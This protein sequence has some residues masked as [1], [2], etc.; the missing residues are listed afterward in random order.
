MA[1][2]A[3]GEGDTFGKAET[4]R[5][6]P[7]VAIGLTGDAARLMADFAQ[8]FPSSPATADGGIVLPPLTVELKATPRGLAAQIDPGCFAADLY[9]R[10]CAAHLCDG[11]PVIPPTAERVSAMLA[12]TDFEP[13]HALVS[14]LPPSGASITVRSLAVNA[15]MAGCRSE[16]F[17]ILITAFQAIAD[18]AYRAYQ[19]AITTLKDRQP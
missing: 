8:R 7:D 2:P 5:I 3:S 12:F 13:E 19:G 9:D 6:A 16:Y 4:A 17:P 1:F 14:E 11:L 18:P 10:L 15:V